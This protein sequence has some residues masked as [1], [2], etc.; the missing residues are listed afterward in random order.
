MPVFGRV[1]DVCRR[2]GDTTFPLFGSLVDGAVFEELG[3]ALFC[4]TLG[5]GCCEGRLAVIDVTD[6][7]YLDLA[8]VRALAL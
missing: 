3:E 2:D 8:R 6:G 1:L 4:L 5:D 7:S